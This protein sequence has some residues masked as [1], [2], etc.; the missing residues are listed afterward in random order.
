M[1]VFLDVFFVAVLLFFMFRGWQRGFA[2]SVLKSGRWILSLMITLSFGSAFSS[3]IDRVWIHPPVYE[4]IHARFTALADAAGGQAEVLISRVP[5]VF[6][7]YLDVGVAEHTRDLYRLTDEWSQSVSDG[8]SG[9]I[10]SVIGYILLF[11]IV[12]AVLTLAVV[13]LRRLT[14]LPVVG[15]LD[16]LLGLALGLVGG[17]LTAVFLALIL[18]AVLRISGNEEILEQTFLLRTVYSIVGF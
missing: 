6:R 7:P 14:N 15:T 3:F 11:L 17:L 10:S 9:T 18:G 5:V 8:I 13:L 1:H 16:H 2:G 4:K 12:Y